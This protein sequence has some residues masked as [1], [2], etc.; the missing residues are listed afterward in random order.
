MASVVLASAMGDLT[1]D[2]LNDIA[3]K[4]SADVKKALSDN[5]DAVKLFIEH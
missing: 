5:Q 3:N 1:P 4:A 2:E